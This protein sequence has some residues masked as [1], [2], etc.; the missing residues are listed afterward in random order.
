MDGL[1]PI[2]QHY[3]F[4]QSYQTDITSINELFLSQPLLMT[5]MEHSM[6]GITVVTPEYDIF[7][8]NEAMKKW[9]SLHQVESDK[10]CYSMFHG[11]AEKCMDCPVAK[12]MI[13]LQPHRGTVPY[14]DKGVQIGF[15]DLYAVPVLDADSNV[16]GIIEYTHNVSL[17]IAM[18][19][20]LKTIQARFE[21][22]Q[23]QNEILESRLEEQIEMLSNMTSYVTE[24]IEK[25][26]K[27]SL[28]NLKKETSEADIDAVSSVLDTIFEPF[29]RQKRSALSVL[30]VRELQ[31]ASLIKEGKTS[32]EIAAALFITKKAVD[33]HRRNIRQKMKVDSN[34][35]L[36]TFLREYL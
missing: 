2:N 4:E 12:S 18:E 8:M 9:Y 28:K 22:L 34:V 36:H 23:K 35:S 19:K 15:L 14:M 3:L 29:Q 30:S 32:K 5:M 1:Y 13:D 24:S 33:F 21:I 7:Y 17:Q 31:V 25:Y 16:I 26:V 27:P 20:N 11:N 10:K 6:D